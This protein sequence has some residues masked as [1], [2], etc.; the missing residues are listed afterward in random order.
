MGFSGIFVQTAL[1]C[2][3]ECTD[4]GMTAA[5][6]YLLAV[7]GVSVFDPSSFLSLQTH[8]SLVTCWV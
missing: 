4:I 5:R 6:F 8:P 2:V 3:R 1:L 7:C